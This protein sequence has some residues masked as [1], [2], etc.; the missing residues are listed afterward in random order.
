MNLT[1]IFVLIAR[2]NSYRKILEILLILLENLYKLMWFFIWFVDVNNLY[3]KYIF[4]FLFVT[5]GTSLYASCC[6]S[7]NIPK[8]IYSNTCLLSSW[9]ITNQIH[10]YIICKF[11]LVV[12]FVITI[13]FFQKEKFITKYKEL[14]FVIK[15][16]DINH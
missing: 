3:I 2:N 7:Y 15:N 11:F 6:K 9:S 10:Y 8:F 16:Y 12:K 5:G 14:I 13:A 4:E 1:N